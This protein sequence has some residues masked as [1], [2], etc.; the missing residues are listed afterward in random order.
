MKKKILAVHLLNNYSGSP[1]VFAS[2]LDAL[3]AQ[4]HEVTLLS[5]QGPGFLDG[6]GDHFVQVPYRWSANKALRLLRFALSQ[7]YLFFRL[8]AWWPQEVTLYIN[9]LLPFGAAMAA[10]LMGKRVVYY[11]HETHIDPPVLNRWLRFWVKHAADELIIVSDYLRR[12]LNFQGIPYT[13]VPNVLPEELLEDS[14]QAPVEK[15][16]FHLLMAASLKAGKG[17]EQF[18]QLA[19]AMPDF[20]FTLIIGSARENI[21]HFLAG[22]KLPS[23]LR[24]L[25]RQ[26]DM[27]P[28][29]RQASLLLNLSVP[30]LFHE[31]F[32]MTILE[33]MAYGL[34]V[35]VPPVGAPADIVTEGK[36]GFLIDSR[37]TE[38]LKACIESLAAAPATYARMAEAARAT[39]RTYDPRSFAAGVG[40]VFAS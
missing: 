9:T 40:Q 26:G 17:L 5:S 19:E 25:D 32:G 8:L 7:V 39:A 34:P 21:Q 33:G 23:N 3:Q 4:G 15:E 6:K 37:D 22:R 1:R 18:I 10:R 13:V 11:C 14:A 27:R 30:G 38:S 35:I 28:F 36:D 16:G 2:A 20:P 12:E 24:L 31:T 29:Y